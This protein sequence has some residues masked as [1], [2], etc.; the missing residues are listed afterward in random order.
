[1]RVLNVFLFGKEKAVL[2]PQS[3]WKPFTFCLGNDKAPLETAMIAFVGM[4]VSS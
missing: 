2:F 3:Y 4:R 1:M